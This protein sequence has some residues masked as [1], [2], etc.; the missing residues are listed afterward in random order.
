MVITL[1][2]VADDGRLSSAKVTLRDDLVLEV[3]APSS[4]CANAIGANAIWLAKV[5]ASRAAII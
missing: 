3:E 5:T 2:A 4:P 1:A